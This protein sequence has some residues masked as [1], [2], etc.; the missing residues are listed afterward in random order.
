M[1]DDFSRVS[2]SVTPDTPLVP[3]FLQV[4]LDPLHS[5]LP[6]AETRLNPDNKKKSGISILA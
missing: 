2:A 1:L 5:V 3:S 4:R 6:Y